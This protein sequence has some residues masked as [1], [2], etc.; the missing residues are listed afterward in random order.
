MF[1]KHRCGDDLKSSFLERCHPQSLALWQREAIIRLGEY[2]AKKDDDDD[3]GDGDGEE[4]DAFAIKSKLWL[5][6]T[7]RYYGKTAFLH[8]T[9]A[10]LFM[11]IPN[12][13]IQ[14]WCANRRYAVKFNVAVSSWVERNCSV[15]G[16]DLETHMQCKN[17]EEYRL[18]CIE[19]NDTRTITYVSGNF[20][21]TKGLCECDIYV[22]DDVEHVGE[23]MMNRILALEKEA[24]VLGAGTLQNDSNIFT[25]LF[26]MEN[27]PGSDFF[28]KLE[29]PHGCYA[30]A[31]SRYCQHWPGNPA[32]KAQTVGS[33][34]N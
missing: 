26:D 5:F 31:R 33:S 19:S 6:A 25:K 34:P 13:T 24:M 22:I 23:D 32:P 10:S 14:V 8:R 28:E 11:T 15:E 18:C 4:N 12:V 17:K 16:V 27:E 7:P 20:E 2:F 3:D 9:V 21:R 1:V 30:C 29:I